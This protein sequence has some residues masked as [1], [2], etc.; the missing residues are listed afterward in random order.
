MEPGP[1]DDLFIGE[2]TLSARLHLAHLGQA[3]L[4]DLAD[5]E[6]LAQ[7]TMAGVERFLAPGIDLFC[8]EMARLGRDA[9][10][11]MLENGTGVILVRDPSKSR[12]DEVELIFSM[13]VHESLSMRG[14]LRLTTEMSRGE[15]SEVAGMCGLLEDLQQESIRAAL[16]SAWRSR[17]E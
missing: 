9:S 8:A 4:D 15:R 14:A 11:T 16:M 6:R 3:R 13:R 7:S 17:G 10:F 5:Q 2:S 1:Q 12:V